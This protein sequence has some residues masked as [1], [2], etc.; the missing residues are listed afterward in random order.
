VLSTDWW[1]NVKLTSILLLESF[2][3]QEH[4]SLLFLLPET[5]DRKNN[6]LEQKNILQATEE[7]RLNRTCNKGLFDAW[8]YTC[9]TNNMYLIS[10]TIILKYIRKDMCEM[11]I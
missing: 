9:I 8:N 11:H 2:V 6:G 5:K 7:E 10:D 1:K 4:F 3:E